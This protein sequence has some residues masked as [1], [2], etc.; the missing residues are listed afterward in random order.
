V[1]AARDNREGSPPPI[2]VALRSSGI[3][4]AGVFAS[5][6][7]QFLLLILVTRGTG[8]QGAGVF[9]ESLA[10]FAIAATIAQLGTDTAMVRLLP[11]HALFRPADARETYKVAIV[12]V[13]VAATLAS[14][15]LWVVAPSLS[16]VLF[17]GE[18]PAEMARYLRMLAPFL[19]ISAATVVTLAATR[20][21]G[22]VHPYVL[23][24]NVGLPAARLV[25]VGLAIS[26]G[27]SSGSMAVAWALPSILGLLAAWIVLQRRLRRVEGAAA[28]ARR[29]VAIA[30]EVWHFA[31]PRAMATSFG[32][33]TT[34]VD[35]VL[36][37]ALVGTR[38]AGIYAA[39]SRLAVIGA[40]GLEA[41]GTALAP[42]FS[43]LIAK[44]E[45]ANVQSLLESATCWVMVALWPLYLVLAFFPTS[46][47]AIFGSGFSE[48][49]AALTVLSV[50]M[51][52]NLGTGNVSV[53]LLMAGKSWWNLSNA[54]IAATANVLLNLV[55]IPRIGIVGA[56][57]AWSASIFLVNGLAVTEVWR[58][59]GI[60][61]FGRNYL[62]A[63]SGPLVTFGIL[64]WLLR[65]WAGD[66]PKAMVTAILLSI[67]PY[68]AILWRTRDSLGWNELRAL[69]RDA[70]DPT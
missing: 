17:G 63:A 41:V 46:A 3:S 9:F 22:N 39:T 4:V 2:R 35:V 28:S 53:V 16:R 25:T 31:G 18:D 43:R 54:A 6:V 70:P 37:G 42:I 61:P 62:V 14:V 21:L 66:E 60:R 13:L 34:W 47:L 19:P 69:G 57:Y 8:S 59:L 20:G 58:T 44:G 15:A 5:A 56:A 64:C 49:A 23:V 32:V 29:R 38:E 67:P 51:L 26:A 1:T 7:L 65:V 68:A 11:Q 10:I 40:Y 12:P 55:L 52:V 30:S 27:L 45:R 33:V 50:A 36:V 48:G 24:Q